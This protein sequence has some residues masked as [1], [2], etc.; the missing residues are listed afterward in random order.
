VFVSRPAASS[1]L[2]GVCETPTSLPPIRRRACSAPHHQPCRVMLAMSFNTTDRSS[3]LREPALAWQAAAVVR[4]P[5]GCRLAGVC[6]KALLPQASHTDSPVHFFCFG[7]ACL[8]RL[9]QARVPADCTPNVAALTLNQHS[10]WSTVH[11]VNHLIVC[12]MFSW[13]HSLVIR[14]LINQDIY[15]YHPIKELIHQ[16]IPLEKSIDTYI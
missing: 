5:A 12:C 4:E 16:L 10:V 1:R 14:R 3:A 13:N 9:I 2:A 11:G 6:E 7:T 8:E 15:L